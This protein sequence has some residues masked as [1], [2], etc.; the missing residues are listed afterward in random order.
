MAKQNIEVRELLVSDV[1]AIFADPQ[2]GIDIITDVLIG[3]PGGE[4]KLLTRCTDLTEEE[5]GKLGFGEFTHLVAAMKEANP[6][7]FAIY[8]KKMEKLEQL[9]RERG[10]SATPEPSTGSPGKGTEKP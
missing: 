10:P 8:Q 2:V 9:M 4:I 6:D 1:E 3:K 5:I 7:F